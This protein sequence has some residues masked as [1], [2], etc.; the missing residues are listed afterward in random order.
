MQPLLPEKQMCLHLES[1]DLCQEALDLP[2]WLAWLLG[3][4]STNDTEH[5]IRLIGLSDGCVW[6]G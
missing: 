1:I 5:A 6:L 4:G 2:I 3:G